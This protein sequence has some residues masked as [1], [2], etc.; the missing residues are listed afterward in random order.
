MKG[1]KQNSK[2]AQHICDTGYL[3]SKIEKTLE[4]FH[5]E[6]ERQLLNTLERFHIYKLSKQTL[7]MNDIF[8]IKNHPIFTVILQTHPSENTTQGNPPHT[9]TTVQIQQH[10]QTHPSA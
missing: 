3:F 9:H 5:T 1:S 8:S 7:Q 10:N 2:Y 6:M 4:V